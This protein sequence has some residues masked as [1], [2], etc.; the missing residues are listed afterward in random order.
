MHEAE[1]QHHPLLVQSVEGGDS[2]SL[3]LVSGQRRLDSPQNPV[4]TTGKPSFDRGGQT[5]H[6]CRVEATEGILRRLRL[7]CLTFFRLSQLGRLL[8]RPLETRLFQP[9]CL[10]LRHAV[11]PELRKGRVLTLAEGRQCRLQVVHLV[12]NLCYRVPW[13]GWR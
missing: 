12:E 5:V 6:G 7:G 9:Q 8:D 10:C 13:P 3:R 4:V 11:V 1:V 2:S